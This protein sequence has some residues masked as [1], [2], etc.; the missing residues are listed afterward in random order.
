MSG[1]IHTKIPTAGLFGMNRAYSWNP[2]R[3]C[4][5]Y[6]CP[7][8]PKTKGKCWAAKICNRMAVSWAKAD[9]GFHPMDGLSDKSIMIKTRKDALENFEPFW[10]QSQFDKKF[11]K[12]RSCILVGYQTDLAFVPLAWTDRIIGKILDN[13]RERESAGL[14]LHI[15]PFLTKAPKKLY[16]MHPFP[17]NCWL[18]FTMMDDM[19]QKKAADVLQYS[20]RP[21]NV[22]YAYME[23]LIE[24]IDPWLIPRFDWVIVGGG[25][26]PLNPDWVRSIRN[27]CQA[28]NI[29]FYFKGFNWKG[30]NIW[31][32][33]KRQ[34]NE[35]NP[36]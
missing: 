18:G 27:Q 24:K 31:L 17:I 29:P 10:F 35:K 15:F 9:Y 33:W 12:Q 6:S 14:P 4:A 28:A 16:P 36:L 11:P 1:L 7:L 3:G 22:I 19:G 26:N 13:N 2:V 23:P 5:N 34:F 25:P 32:E 8:H 20:Q 30:I 21:K